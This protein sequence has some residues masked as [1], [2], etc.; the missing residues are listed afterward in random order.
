MRRRT[1]LFGKNG[2]KWCG[3]FSAEPS[4]KKISSAMHQAEEGAM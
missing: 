4:N 1:V 3:V 2:R